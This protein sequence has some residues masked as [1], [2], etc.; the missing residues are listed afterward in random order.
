MKYV[1]EIIALG[2]YEG[3]LKRA[4]HR[5]K[6]LRD[7]EPARKLARELARHLPKADALV[8]VPVD[9]ETALKRGYNQARIIADVL[10]QETGIPVMVAL[11]KCRKSIPQAILH[12][13]RRPANVRGCFSPTNEDLKGKTVIVVDDLTASGS[14]LE[15]AAR[16]LRKM[17]ARKVIAAVLAISEHFEVMREVIESA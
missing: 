4:I 6:F 9:R 1:N 14:T 2:D 17:G 8:P 13:L 11:R 12:P 15:E 10:S 3:E 7:P 16:I 5:L